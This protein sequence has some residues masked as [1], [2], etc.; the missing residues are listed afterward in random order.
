M[1]VIPLSTTD[2]RY[3][4][5]TNNSTIT[6]GRSTEADICIADGSVSRNHCFLS[7][8]D[9]Q[10][11]IQDNHSA[12]GTFVNSNKIQL[13]DIKQGDIIEIGV[14]QLQIQ[15]T[16]P[17]N[18][19]QVSHLDFPANHSITRKIIKPLP[20]PLADSSVADMGHKARNVFSSIIS[21]AQILLAMDLDEEQREF[22]KA[23]DD[24]ARPFLKTIHDIFV[25][26]KLE[27]S[28]ERPQLQKCALRTVMEKIIDDFQSHAYEKKIGLFLQIM[29]DVPQYIVY[30][31]EHLQQIVGNLISNAIQFTDRGSVTVEIEKVKNQSCPLLVF[32][33]NDTGSGIAEEQYPKLFRRF[34][35]ISQEH[36]GTGLGLFIAKKLV[37]NAGGTIWFESS[38]GRGSRFS[39]SIPILPNVDSDKSSPRILLADDY[40]PNQKFLSYLLNCAGYDVVTVE[41]GKQVLAALKQQVFDI[42]LL[43]LQMPEMSGLEVAAAIKEHN[44]SEYD[45]RIPLV[46]LTAYTDQEKVEQ[47][48]R[49]GIEEYVN[50]PIDKKELLQKISKLLA[51]RKTNSEVDKATDQHP[52]ISRQKRQSVEILQQILE[53]TSTQ[54][55]IH[56]AK[57]LAAITHDIN[58]PLGIIK[59]NMPVLRDYL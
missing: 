4:S 25:L 33:I 46:A 40:Y 12:N 27:E 23:I 21:S 16:P 42:V 28:I 38:P 10:L 39:F 54:D 3:L 11:Q 57:L 55:R 15:S 19:Y 14:M 36:Q 6:I 35:C 37:E 7:Y 49:V 17:D 44:G 9:D 13:M 51:S 20:P 50:K 56:I 2:D 31:V 34:G 43:D 29:P 1:Y 32:A 24:A 8:Q 53:K 59:M 47:C 30:N 5:L 22:A 52:Q 58:N 48:R 41:N 45:P 18:G 26:F